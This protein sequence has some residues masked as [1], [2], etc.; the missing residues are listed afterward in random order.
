MEKLIL[1]AREEAIAQRAAEIAVARVTDEFY[2]Q[3]GKSVV[4]RLLVWVGVM[5]VGFGV[6]KGWVKWPQ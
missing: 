3:V 6:A 2:N 4:T 1:T 5:V